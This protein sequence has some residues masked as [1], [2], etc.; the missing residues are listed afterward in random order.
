MLQALNSPEYMAT[1]FVDF[2]Y[3]DATLFDLIPIVEAITLADIRKAAANFFK[4][5]RMSVFRIL[6]LGEQKS[7]VETKPTQEET[8]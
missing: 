1:Q 6:P 3:E 5:E 4:E 2:Y 8:Q 7:I